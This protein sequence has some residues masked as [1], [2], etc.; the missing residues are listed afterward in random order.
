[1]AKTFPAFMEPEIYCRVRKI[2]GPYHILIQF[3]RI[4]VSLVK[5]PLWYRYSAYV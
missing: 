4:T 5:D 1:M 3:V 2:N